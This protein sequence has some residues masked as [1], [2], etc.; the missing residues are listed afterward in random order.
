MADK[1]ISLDTRPGPFQMA[2]Q[3]I[4]RMVPDRD[5]GDLRLRR[6]LAFRLGVDGEDATRAYLMR[7]IRDAIQEH[8]SSQLYQRLARGR[9]ETG[10]GARQPSEPA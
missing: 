9:A 6:L 10:A 1:V 5:R 8:D 3:R 7:T 2:F 4:L